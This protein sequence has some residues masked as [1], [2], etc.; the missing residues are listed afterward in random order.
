MENR[1]SS[2]SL[3]FIVNGKSLIESN[4]QQLTSLLFRYRKWMQGHLQSKIIKVTLKNTEADKIISLW[5]H[6]RP[7]IVQGHPRSK[8][9]RL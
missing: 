6:I 5:F 9:M 3:R 1:P 4:H 8:E 7:E 2:N